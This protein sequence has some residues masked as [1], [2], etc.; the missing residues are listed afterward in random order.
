MSCLNI[1]IERVLYSNININTEKLEGIN[2]KVDIISNKLY[3]QT[4]FDLLNINIVKNSSTLN[5]YPSKIN[6]SVDINFSIIWD[7]PNIKYLKVNPKEVQWIPSWG[8]TYEIRS[9]TEWEV[10]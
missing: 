7:V 1:N 5:I 6:K 8:L 10:N 2:T 4:G 9:N 3:I